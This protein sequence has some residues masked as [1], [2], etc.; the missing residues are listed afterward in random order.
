MKKLLVS[1]VVVGFLM[2]LT[3]VFYNA[4]FDISTWSAESRGFTAFLI[5]FGFFIGALIAKGEE[6]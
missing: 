4:T 3:G 1:A 6:L 5:V 2:Y